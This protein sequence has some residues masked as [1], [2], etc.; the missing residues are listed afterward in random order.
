VRGVDGCF[1]GFAEG[2]LGWVA[3]GAVNDYAQLWGDL[4]VFWGRM[5]IYAHRQFIAIFI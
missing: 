3:S 4:G 1:W 5:E 2:C